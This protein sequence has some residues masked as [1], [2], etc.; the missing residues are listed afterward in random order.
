[1]ESRYVLTEYRKAGVSGIRFGDTLELL[2]NGL[3]VIESWESGWGVDRS[4]RRG[5]YG[6][7]SGC[8]LSLVEVIVFV[9]RCAGDIVIPCFGKMVI[10]VL[11]KSAS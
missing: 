7:V 1:M 5:L 11:A 9:T 2:S 4:E 3:A 10:F 8:L 6:R